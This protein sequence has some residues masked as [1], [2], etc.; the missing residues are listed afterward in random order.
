MTETAPVQISQTSATSSANNATT[1]ATEKALGRDDFLKLLVAQLKNQD[2]LNP[3][4]NTE[5]VTQLAQFSSLEQVMG[6][7]DRLDL[8]TTQSR[9]QGNTESIGLVG[10]QVT[11][12]GSNLSLDGS[13]SGAELSFGLDADAAKTDVA[14]QD[15]S[16]HTVRTLHLGANAAG[17]VKAHWDGLDDNGVQQPSGNYTVSIQATSGANAAV[18]VTQQ[19]SGIVQSVSFDKGYAVL[20]LDNGVSVPV[21]DL[22][23]V[24]DPAAATAAK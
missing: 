6:I 20:A 24:S 14:I 13:G 4:Q 18:G 19:T 5:F 8:L 21:S 11:V 10:K 15:A 16:G 12:H 17:V 1:N 2:P 9:G 22:V 7:N 23:E 3:V